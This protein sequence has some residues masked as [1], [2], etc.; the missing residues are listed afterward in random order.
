MPTNEEEVEEVKV[1]P[2]TSKFKLSLTSNSNPI[3][4]EYES[5][6]HRFNDHLRAAGMIIPEIISE[7]TGVAGPTEEEEKPVESYVITLDDILDKLVM[8]MDNVY[9]FTFAG[10]ASAA[11]NGEAKLEY[12]K[13]DGSFVVLSTIT[14]DGANLKQSIAGASLLFADNV[15]TPAKYPFVLQVRVS[16]KASAGTCSLWLQ[17]E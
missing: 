15:E 1:E 17:T 14:G 16:L 12:Q 6:K 4:F 10:Q 8:F 5:D 11:Y 3:S 9:D 7:L 2:S 13:V